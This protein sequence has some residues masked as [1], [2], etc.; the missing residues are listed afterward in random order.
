[1]RLNLGKYILSPL[2]GAW[3]ENIFQRFCRRLVACLD[4]VGIDIARRAYARMTCS[5]RN[6]R[7]RNARRNLQ[8]NICMPQTVKRNV[9]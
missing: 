1:M 7:E 9:G 8:S 3:Q 2:F 6:R 4:E 5:A